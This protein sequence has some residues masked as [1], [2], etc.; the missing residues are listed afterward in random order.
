MLTIEHQVFGKLIYDIYWKRDFSISF[1]N[2]EVQVTLVVAGDEDA[3]FEECQIQAF[4][5]FNQD[6]TKITV[7]VENSIYQYYLSV[8]DENRMRFGEQSD[9]LSPLINELREL[10]PLITLKQIIVVESFDINEREI[11][12]VIDAMWEP[13][14]GIGVKC[15]NGKVVE[16]GNQDIIL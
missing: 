5:E 15:V 6:I 12:F 4:Q 11:G 14:L 9:E 1:L 16:V 8:C 10:E 3:D 2:K 7:D 13:E